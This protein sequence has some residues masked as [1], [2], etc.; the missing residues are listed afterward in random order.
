MPKKIL[1]S[2]LLLCL[3][4]VVRL[5]AANVSILVIETGLP[6]ENPAQNYSLMW[7]NGLMDVLFEAGHIV[8]NA[9]ILRLSGKVQNGFPD[10]AERDMGEAR[11]NGMRY[12][13]VAVVN[14]PLPY[15]V[16]LRLFSTSSP[17]ML[18]EVKYTYKA[19]KSEKEEY[20]NIKKAIREMTTRIR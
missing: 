8:S 6:K 19:P 13:L 20:D 9:P 18:Y 4:A 7:E 17:E 11:E 15:N 3:F 2:Q 1:L 5:E 10:E 16:S 14:Y 12:F